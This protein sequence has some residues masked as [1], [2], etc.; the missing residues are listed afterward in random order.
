MRLIGFVFLFSLLLAGLAP[1]KSSW[2]EF[3]IG[4]FL[5]DTDSDTGAARDALT[6]L[7]QLRWVLGGLLESKDLSSIWPIRILLTNTAAPSSKFVLQTGHYLLIAA[8]G[9]R[10]PLELVASLLLDENTPRLPAEI[11]SG[12]PQLFATLEARGS[13]VT[14]GGPPAQPDLAWARMQLFATKPEYAGRFHILMTNLRGGASLSIAERNSFGKDP[15][16]IEK[17]AADNL[18]SRAWSP[19]PVSGRP[20]DPKRDFGQHTI[21]GA[22]AALYLA[23]AQLPASRQNAE[24]ACKAVVEL[25]GQ[26][27][28]LGYE[29]LAQVAILENEDPLPILE[30]AMKAG[31]RSAPVYLEASERS[32]PADELPLLKKAALFNPR[33]AEP[34]LRQAKLVSDPA[35]REDLLK[36]AAQ[37]DPRSASTLQ[38]LAQV[39]LANNH[40]TAARGTWLRAENAAATPEEREKIHQRR[41]DFE[42][43]RLDAVEEERRRSGEAARAEDERAQ[44]AQAARIHAAEERAN[45]KLDAEAGGEKPSAAV[46]WDEM[47][48]Q[49]VQGNLVRVDCL[50]GHQRLIVAADGGKTVQLYVG[51]PSQ[52]PPLTCG[53]QHPP[54]KIAVAYSN[55]ADRS[56]GTMGDVV[57]ITPQ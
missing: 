14:W 51:D 21:Q 19:A 13:R 56:L 32:L 43:N 55:R 50:S 37:L 5:V 7:E 29:A 42:E 16:L 18:A 34:I 30:D 2:E 40:L 28:A 22:V 24:A 33:W 10:L 48:S 44:N 53:P 35:E 6:Q 17:E 23:A 47:A 39:Q 52:F 25:G 27:T 3:N 9:K 49:K 38:A 1:A 36:Q 8:P 31:S 12:I 26:A 45:Q 46:P 4:P 15:S 20:L 54:K 41:L 11:E 57:K